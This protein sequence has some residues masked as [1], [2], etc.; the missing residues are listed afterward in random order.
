M[1]LLF[2]RYIVLLLAFC[3]PKTSK[4][5]YSRPLYY[6]FDVV[7]TSLSI[8]KVVRR[9]DKDIVKAPSLQVVAEVLLRHVMG[10]IWGSRHRG[11]KHVEELGP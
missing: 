5:S 2:C 4:P 3:V 10:K 8:I 11:C 1:V 6:N 9:W 7:L